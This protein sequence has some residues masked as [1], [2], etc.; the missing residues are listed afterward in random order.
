MSLRSSLPAHA[1][2]SSNPSFV[3]F[4]YSVYSVVN[5]LVS[6]LCAPRSDWGRGLSWLATC[7]RMLRLSGHH[8]TVRNPTA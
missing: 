6:A 4:V 7:C 5:P 8:D 1:R 2:V 3:V